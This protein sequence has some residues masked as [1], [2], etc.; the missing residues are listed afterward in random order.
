MHKIGL[1]ST[2]ARHALEV[3]RADE[4][5]AVYVTHLVKTLDEALVVHEFRVADHI[6]ENHRILVHFTC[7]ASTLK[8]LL[9]AFDDNIQQRRSHL[10]V[11]KHVLLGYLQR[12]L[13]VVTTGRGREQK[14]FLKPALVEPLI[15]DQVCEQRGLSR[16][17]LA[18]DQHTGTQRGNVHILVFGQ[19]WLFY[20]ILGSL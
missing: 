17:A 19:W 7:L 13:D 14:D 18:T 3:L 4:R 5:R 11:G 15:R 20:I 2:H 6:V 16:P 9:L 1:Q 10:Q 8:L 12:T